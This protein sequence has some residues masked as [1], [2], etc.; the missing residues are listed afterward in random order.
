M[1]K[2]RSCLEGPEC[3]GYIGLPYVT[4]CHMW[5][6]WSVTRLL[7]LTAPAEVA[8]HRT[9]V[10][11]SGTVRRGRSV[12]FCVTF[13][14][15]FLRWLSACSDF[16]RP[17]LSGPSL[18]FSCDNISDFENWKAL[19]CHVKYMRIPPHENWSREIQSLPSSLSEVRRNAFEV[20]WERFSIPQTGAWPKW[21]TFWGPSH[22]FLLQFERYAMPQRFH[23]FRWHLHWEKGATTYVHLWSACRL[24]I[25]NNKKREW[26]SATS[27]HHIS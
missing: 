19:Y 1:C 11:R 22:G 20:P 24:R 15:D 6:P 16:L 12:I 7:L 10:E 4:I 5:H 13:C 26:R 17:D 25:R 23:L 18:N 21:R 27:T 9:S 8:A 3:T 2:S 14:G